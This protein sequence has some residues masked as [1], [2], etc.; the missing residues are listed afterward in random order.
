MPV[1]FCKKKISV[2]NLTSLDSAGLNPKSPKERFFSFN[3]EKLSP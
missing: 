1:A 2:G 3:Q